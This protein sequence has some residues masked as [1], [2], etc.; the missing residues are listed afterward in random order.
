MDVAQLGSGDYVIAGA[1]TLRIEGTRDFDKTIS[2]AGTFDT[3]GA[4]TFSGDARAHTG[5]TKVED[6]SLTIAQGALLGTGAFDVAGTL[7]LIG[8]RTFENATSG[9]GTV[10]VASGNLTVTKNVGTA[11]LHIS[12]GAS[13]TFAGT[14]DGFSGKLT[15]AGAL[16]T[17]QNFEVSGDASGFSGKTSVTAGTFTVSESAKLGS[18]AFDIA[19][20]LAL[21]GDR[22]L[23]NETSGDGTIEI[24]S[25]ATTFTTD[26]GTKTL[27][28]A[29]GASAT[30]NAG[31]DLTHANAE[32]QIAGTLNLSGMRVLAAQMSGNG[33]I[34][35]KRGSDVSFTQSVGVKTL[36]VEN[37][38][39][40]RGNVSLIHGADAELSLA[41]TLV[42]N[43]DKGEKVALGGGK[44]VLANTATLDLIG[45]GVA[46]RASS[47]EI[48]RLET[49]EEVTIF[50]GGSVLGDVVSFLKTD[51][52]LSAYATDYAVVYDTTGGLSVQV[53]KSAE[54]DASSVKMPDGW[55]DAFDVLTSGFTANYKAGFYS[56]SELENAGFDTSD[57]LVHA[58]LTNPESA[59]DMAMNILPGHYAA[60]VAMKAEA[61]YSDV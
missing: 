43:A 57:P 61:F 41:G 31:V 7:V 17:T 14:S 38:A 9:T 28:V 16:T 42:V 11:T 36:S 18:G 8:D 44:A 46:A 3:S 40:L 29:Q 10:D 53:V 25:G 12:S 22:T 51:D 27:S 60:V 15:G 49:G 24:F 48:Q 55:Q 52:D 33:T 4:I 1:G 37:G 32:A 45:N 56:K 58:I 59:R 35:L 34:V 13:A 23:A 5:T 20:T 54:L 47:V 21:N 26:V 6:G 30:L 19:G 50:E 39:T 2:G